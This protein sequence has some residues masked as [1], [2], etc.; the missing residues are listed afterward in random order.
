MAYRTSLS[1]HGPSPACDDAPGLGIE[2]DV[3]E[4]FQVQPKQRDAID[5]FM[6]NPKVSREVGM[7]TVGFCQL[8]RLGNARRMPGGF[9]SLLRR[10]DRAT[11]IS[12]LGVVNR[13]GEPKPD[14]DKPW[15]D[16]IMLER[17]LN[18]LQREDHFS[19][20]NA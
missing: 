3:S 4:A 1:I 10:G 13:A 14:D 2:L 20:S 11:C 6:S 15:H 12:V 5:L 17:P 8:I 16:Q 9:Y 7:P 18:A 19:A